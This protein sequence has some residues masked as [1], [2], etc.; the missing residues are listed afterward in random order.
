M[1]DIISEITDKIAISDITDLD[2]LKSLLEFY[3]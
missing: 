2:I 3:G 1:T